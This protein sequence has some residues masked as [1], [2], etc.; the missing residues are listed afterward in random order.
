[1]I[2]NTK[3][4][5][6]SAT[7]ALKTTF[8]RCKY[9]DAY[10]DSN[11]KTPSWDGTIFVYS[12]GEQKKEH[13]L[14]TVPVQVKGT[15]QKIVSEEASFSCSVVDL[16]NYYRDGGCIFFLVSV[17][18]STQWHKIYYASLLT[19]DLDAILKKA[20]KQKSYTI[21]LKSFPGESE[22]EMA[23]IFMDFVKNKPKQMSFIGK[24][25]PSVETL[26]QNGT[27]IE[28]LSFGASGVGIKN[29]EIE[30]YITTHDF[31]L[32]AKP[33]GLDIDIPVEKVSNPIISKKINGSI[34]VNGVEY[35]SSYTVIYEKGKATFQIGKGLSFIPPLEKESS[36]LQIRPA[37]TLSEFIK[38]TSFIVDV[39]EHKELSINGA[40]LPFNDLPVGE[41]EQIKTNFEY[42]KN[43]KKTLDILGVSEELECDNL[44]EQD[45]R[46]IRNL[47]GAILYGKK[48]TLSHTDAPVTYCLIKIAN[49]SVLIWAE[50]QSDEKYVIK[51]FFEKHSVCVFESNDLE[52]INPIQS[53]QYLL[54]KKRAFEC[55][56]NIDCEMILEDLISTE[57]SQYLMSQSVLFLLE[58]LKGYDKN[59][60]EELLN[61]ATRILDWIEENNIEISKDVILLN[62][63]QILKRQRKLTFDELVSLAELKKDDKPLEIRCGAY[64]LLDDNVN[65]QNCFDIMDEEMKKMFI[66]YPIC[67]FGKLVLE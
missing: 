20:K 56:S 12:N 14:G 31:Y 51:N 27:V 11:D 67:I 55:A 61:L 10:I 37:G 46:N 19:F 26:E 48:M 36:K 62:R 7:T 1:M 23:N 50:K 52:H 24:D 6:E 42:Y 8:L 63:M 32:Y 44:S 22:A 38:D 43:V 15:T 35:Y 28:S 16:K 34:K 25:I 30:R 18:P 13:L 33:K 49:L 17:E 59:P 54:L 66:D 47:V 5:E 58:I 60:K 57:P 3:R 65:A 29:G 40:K 9:I 64:L 53:S 4:I 39:I 21:K 45:Q 2:V 41:V